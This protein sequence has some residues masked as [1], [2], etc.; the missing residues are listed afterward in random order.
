MADL[1]PHAWKIILT[2]AV[3]KAWYQWDA[4]PFNWFQVSTTSWK[5]KRLSN[6]TH[7]MI[8]LNPW[9]ILHRSF[10]LGIA[11]LQLPRPRA[12][13]END[14]D[15]DGLCV[16]MVPSPIPWFHCVCINHI[17]R[18]VSSQKFQESLLGAKHSASRVKFLRKIL[19]LKWEC[20]SEAKIN[21]FNKLIETQFTRHWN[22]DIYVFLECTTTYLTLN[23]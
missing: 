4:R 12:Q 9:H 22:Y 3:V 17:A 1:K 8:E 16:R 5:H 19:S 11:P 14:L 21:V 15:E 10:Q 6:E 13:A 7:N 2:D 23:S 18:F 20:G